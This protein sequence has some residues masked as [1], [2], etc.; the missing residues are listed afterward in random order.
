MLAGKRILIVEPAFSEYEKACLVNSC[1]IEYFRLDDDWDLN[2]ERLKE[3]LREADALFLCN[4]NNPTGVYFSRHIVEE[5]LKECTKQDCL[6]VIDEAFYDFVPDYEPIVPLLKESEHLFI[7]RSLTKMFAIPGL[8]LGFAMSS[9]ER[10]EHLASYQPHWSVNG[11]ALAAGELCLAEEDYIKRTQ[12]LIAFERERLFS[13]YQKQ[14]FAYTPSKVN[15]YLLKDLTLDDQYPLFEY[16][17]QKGIVP[18]HTYNFP[19]LEARW[20]RFAVRSHEEND[21][22]MEVLNQWRKIHRSSL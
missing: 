13:F 14:D 1:Q 15:F 2:L 20:L 4:P 7:L 17:L 22:L 3:R 19:G 9:R 5:L 12:E 8:R 6:L 21:A 11:V 18:R 16:L 10:I